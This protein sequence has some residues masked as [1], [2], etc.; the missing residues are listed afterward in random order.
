VELKT[1]NHVLSMPVAAT[2][3]LDET[4]KDVKMMMEEGSITLKPNTVTLFID[5]I[6]A[7]TTNVDLVLINSDTDLTLAKVTNIAIAFAL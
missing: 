4:T 5:D 7:G 6:P 1:G 2:Y 3:G